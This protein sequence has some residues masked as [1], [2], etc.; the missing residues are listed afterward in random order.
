M[1]TPFPD[2][3]QAGQFPSKKALASDETSSSDIESATMMALPSSTHFWL[4][5]FRLPIFC[6]PTK[7]I[8][9]HFAQIGIRAPLAAVDMGLLRP[10]AGIPRQVSIERAFS[11]HPMRMSSFRLPWLLC[12]RRS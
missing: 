12:L 8:V 11:K 6:P 7:N 2:M 10:A 1:S 3:P 5:N 9:P 4:Q